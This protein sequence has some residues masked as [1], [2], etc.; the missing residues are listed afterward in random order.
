MALIITVAF[1]KGCPSS[2]VT[3]P[4]ITPSADLFVVE[5]SARLPTGAVDV[6]FVVVSV[7]RGVCAGLT[8]AVVVRKRIAIAE[9]IE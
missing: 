7:R 8:T 6:E 9:A 5:G 4:E 3:R 1:G 2:E